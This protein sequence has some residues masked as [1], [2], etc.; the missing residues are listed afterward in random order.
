MASPKHVLLYGPP[1]AGKLTLANKLAE[2]FEIRV[3]DNHASIDPALRLFEFGTPEFI[4]LVEH[5]RVTLIA[6]AAKAGLDVV[7]TLV[8]AS[9]EDDEHV[10]K[11]AAA[12][13]EHGGVVYRV[14]LQ[15]SEAVLRERLGQPSRRGTKKITDPD[16]LSRFLARFDTTTPMPGTALRLNTDGLTP[17]DVVPAIAEKASLTLRT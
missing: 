16:Q 4:D 7:T 17:D 5:L 8:Y 3:L 12:T 10:E 1:A 13:E 14:Q 11:L 9:G 15:A 6:A 2:T